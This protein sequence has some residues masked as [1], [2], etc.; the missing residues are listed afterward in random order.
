MEFIELIRETRMY[1]ETSSTSY[2]YMINAFKENEEVT[3][4]IMEIFEGGIDFDNKIGNITLTHGELI[5]YMVEGEPLSGHMQI[6][7]EL[8]IQLPELWENRK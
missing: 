4:V 6:F 8:L 7:E 3:N 5:E 2:N 1:L